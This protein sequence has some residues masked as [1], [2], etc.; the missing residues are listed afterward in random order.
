MITVKCDTE[1]ELDAMFKLLAENDY[2]IYIRR[3]ELELL[4]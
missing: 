1:E 4:V 3:K 2:A